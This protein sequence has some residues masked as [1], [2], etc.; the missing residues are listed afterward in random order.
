VSGHLGSTYAYFVV[1]NQKNVFASGINSAETPS[2]HVMTMMDRRGRTESRE[3]KE[4]YNARLLHSTRYTGVHVQYAGL[5]DE[6]TYPGRVPATVPTA[7]NHASLCLHPFTG[8]G[9]AR[10]S[11]NG[12]GSEVSE[13]HANAAPVGLFGP[14]SF[15]K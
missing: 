13:N 14:T 1:N 7:P 15:G 8:Y 9:T 10:G 5:S 12:Q 2:L 4:E 6:Q 3:R 11:G